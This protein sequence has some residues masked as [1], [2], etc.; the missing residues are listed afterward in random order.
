VS[1]KL[2]IAQFAPTPSASDNTAIAVNPACLVKILRAYMASCHSRSSHIQPHTSR[3]DSATAV[4]LPNSRR[5]RSH[6]SCSGT[7]P[8]ISSSAFSSICA[9]I[10]AA[11]VHT[12]LLK[13]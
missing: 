5:A 9:S 4:A 3:L 2:N 12:C 8:S 7:P 11:K 6:A 1:A 10:S 13:A